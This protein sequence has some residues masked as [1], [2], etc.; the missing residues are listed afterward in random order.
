VEG[1]KIATIPVILLNGTT[2]DA[3]QVMDDFNE[4][5]TNILSSNIGAG[6]STGTGRF[7]LETGATLINPIISGIPLNP[8]FTNGLTIPTG[9]R[10]FLGA[11]SVRE[12][13]ANV[14]TF[15]TSGSDTFEIND[16]DSVRVLNALNF[17]VQAGSRIYLDGPTG[18][19]YL[20]RSAA[21]DLMIVAGGSDSLEV[22]GGNS[23]NI[24]NAM[25]FS[26]QSGSRIYFRGSATGPY[27]YSTGANILR[28][29]TSGSDSFEIDD[30]NSV[31]VLNGL[32]FTVQSGARVTLDGA[33]GND[34]W[35]STANGQNDLMSAGTLTLRTTSGGNVL[36]PQSLAVGTSTA[37]TQVVDANGALTSRVRSS[38]YF[39]ANFS[40]MTSIEFMIDGVT[41]GAN[42]VTVND[43]YNLGSI[44]FSSPGSEDLYTVTFATPMDHANYIVVGAASELGASEWHG[45]TWSA[46]TKTT[47]GI[48]LRIVNA[49]DGTTDVGVQFTLAI[50]GGR[51]T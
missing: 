8:S 44:T 32:N 9:Q 24:L 15:T 17:S 49:S 48:E 18:S 3:N 27:I 33:G 42:P 1:A 20:R 2:A 34:Y 22:D 29:N 7:V 14:V 43:S 4:I 26:L 16:G 10:L 11:S 6:G 21:N 41:T 35:A 25:N 5:Y 19:V 50:I 37:P 40:R 45:V 38:S 12:S 51:N 28:V 30:G 39:A 36:L 31:N 13:A 47:T 46:G 23:V